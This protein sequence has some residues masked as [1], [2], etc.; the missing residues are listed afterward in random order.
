MK[1]SAVKACATG[2]MLFVGTLGVA[3]AAEASL[4][5][6][7]FVNN[8]GIGYTG[9]AVT[10]S[11]GDQWN[12]VRNFSTT[13]Q[14]L[15]DSGG[16]LTSATFSNFG[17][18]RGE[19]GLHRGDTWA[20]STTPYADLMQGYLFSDVS[21]SS[22]CLM[23]IAGLSAGSYNIY[24]LTQG[25]SA[26]AGRRLGVSIGSETQVANASVAAANTFILDQNYLKFSNVAMTGGE[27]FIEWWMVAGEANINGIQIESAVP[28]PGAVALLGVAGL[29]G[30]RRRRA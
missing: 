14:A 4:I 21:Q 24:I 13:G 22:P 18:P 3:S 8:S 1:N 23:T 30:G 12:L 2:V 5:N 9:A 7:Q 17:H 10:G 29:T 11:A 20:F 16:N 25:D 26:T 28:A 19:N 15:T 27:L 6:I